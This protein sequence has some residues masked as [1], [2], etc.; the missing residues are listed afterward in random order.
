MTRHSDSPRDKIVVGVDGSSSSQQALRRAARQARL[1]GGEV[2][3]VS[4]WDYPNTVGWALVVDD[5]DWA[6]NAGRTLG[7]AIT[8]V[9]KPDEASTCTGPSSGVIR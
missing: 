1:T 3:A 7:E 5:V 4:A 8:A 2:H 9:L 6:G